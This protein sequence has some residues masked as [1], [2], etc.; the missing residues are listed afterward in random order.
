MTIWEKSVLNMQRGAKRL[1]VAAVLFADRVKAEIAVVRLR[2]R[3]N[4]VHARIDELYQSIG[5]MVV[6]LALGDALPKSS[7]QLFQNE[8]ISNAMHELADRK[9]ELEELN[10]KIRSEH[11]LFKTAPKRKEGADV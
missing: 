10:E 7:E 2:I 11:N 8:D 9:Q 5:R 4:E 3:I 6:N 1:S